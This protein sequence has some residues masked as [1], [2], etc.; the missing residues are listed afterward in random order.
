LTQC[1]RENRCDLPRDRM[2]EAF[3]AALTHPNPSARL[4]A[5]YGDYAWSVLDDRVLGE[6]MT[7]KAIRTSPNEPV[8][9]ITL[10]RMLAAQ[11]RKT[12]AKNALMQLKALNIGGRLNGSLAELSALP[13]L[14]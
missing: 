14:Q 9:Q 10:V 6:R 11:G 7:K 5:I 13:G 4:L 3:I 8:Y 2:V 1:A 12:D